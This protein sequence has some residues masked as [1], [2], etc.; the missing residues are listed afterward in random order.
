[1]PAHFDV[2]SASRH[3][4]ERLSAVFA[5]AFSDYIVPFALDT[6]A[7]AAV[8]RREG[9]DFYASR[10][11]VADDELVGFANLAPRG[12]TVRVA[13]MGVVPDWRRRG[14]GRGLLEHVFATSAELGARVIELEVIASNTPAVEL[15]EGMGFERFEELASYV[16]ADDDAA[17]A[18]GDRPKPVDLYEAAAACG[19]WGAPMPAQLEP[20]T[21]AGLGPP[22]TAWRLEDATA[23]GIVRETDEQNSVLLALVTSTTLRRSGLGRRL[24]AALRQQ[25]PG[26]T[27]RVPAIAPRRAAEP[28]LT[29]LGWRRDE[30]SQ[31]RMRRPVG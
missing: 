5:R 30:L 7:L 23:Y 16:F 25:F 6:R 12:W 11:A 18:P 17:E 9:V 10:V 29:A 2:E 4:L 26:R 20:A 14:V 8:A 27:W 22:L 15:Y 24:F 28:F 19:R 3:A 31:W 21:L 1:M 13:A